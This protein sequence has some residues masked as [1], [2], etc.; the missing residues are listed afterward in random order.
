M[1]R[2]E[3]G[4]SSHQIVRYGDSGVGTVEGNVAGARAARLTKA[5]ESERKEY[6]EQRKTIESEQR[7]D[8]VKK[9]DEQFAGLMASIQ[10]RQED[11][12]PGAQALE[13]LQQ[14]PQP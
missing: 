11:L 1:A 3:A 7:A 4:S 2:G 5:R 10:V 13:Q 8:A 6:D 12:P 14:K 9:V